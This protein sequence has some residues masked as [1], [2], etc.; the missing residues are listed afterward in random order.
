MVK[1]V[2]CANRLGLAVIEENIVVQGFK[3]D[4]KPFNSKDNEERGR[5]ARSPRRVSRVVKGTEARKAHTV[6]FLYENRFLSYPKIGGSKADA[7]L[8]SYLRRLKIHPPLLVL[9]SNS[10]ASVATLHQKLL[11]IRKT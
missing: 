6:L 9:F 2:P 11:Y 7:G 3:R 10:L 1:S 8:N 5:G 4:F